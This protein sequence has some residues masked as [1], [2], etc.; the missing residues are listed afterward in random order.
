MCTM[1]T[2]GL[3][4]LL[5]GLQVTSVAQEKK[6][7]SLQQCVDSALSRNIRVRQAGLLEQSADVA[8]D[9]AKLNRLPVA[10]ANIFH[11]INEGRSIDPFTNGYVN[12]Q[13][14]Y[15][16]YGLGSNLTLFNG[17]S[18]QHAQRSAAYAYEASRLET[19]QERADLTLQVILAYLQVLNNEDLVLQAKAN[20]DVTQKQLD[21]L[22]VLHQQGAIAPPLLYELK[23]QMQNEMVQVVNAQNALELSRLSLSQLMNTDYDAAMQLERVAFGGPL[24][25]DPLDMPALMQK[26]A[27]QWPLLQ[28]MNLRHK[29]AFHSVKA[30][31]GRLL[32]SLFMGANINTTYS[33]AARR[34]VLL[35]TTEKASNNYVLVN[36][37]KIPVVVQQ[38]QYVSQQ[39][40]YNSQLRNNVYSNVEIGLRLP[41]FNALQTRNRIRLAKI[42]VQN[43]TLQEE[44]TRMR[45]RN[46]M[47]QAAIQLHSAR[48]RTQ[49][50][51]KSVAAFAEAFRTAEVRFNAGVGTVVDY[52][53]AKNN[54]D[55]ARA[56]L[57]RAQYD[58]VLRQ[59]V[60]DYYLSRKLL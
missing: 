20:V 6:S 27:A 17:L 45:L 14:N 58:F 59:K 49:T 12:Q 3:L 33:S 28:A 44:N 36:G 46:E 18:M 1:K 42:E 16:S 47:D 54:L 60:L 22:A 40:D 56:N 2:A 15:A 19:E 57:L 11:G 48:E 13:I 7:L 5:V 9:Q 24:A 38:G 10:N 39:I 50:L 29:S 34:E 25:N 41:L 8:R 51:Q 31:K 21:R 52:L 35:N 26:A 30:E 53:I 32:P 37:S 43:W 55:Q 23:G 4:L